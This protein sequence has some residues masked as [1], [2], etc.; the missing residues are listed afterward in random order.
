MV[1]YKVFKAHSQ[2]CK[3]GLTEDSTIPWVLEEEYKTQRARSK[4]E[5]VGG[6]GAFRAPRR[7]TPTSTF[8]EIVEAHQRVTS[9]MK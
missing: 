5:T 3:T 7:S 4:D 6:A 2:L 9:F 8:L 1:T